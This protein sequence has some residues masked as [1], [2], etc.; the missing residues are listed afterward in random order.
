MYVRS[1][2]ASKFHTRE[3]EGA[4]NSPGDGEA[5]GQIIK[6]FPGKV[7]FDLKFKATWVFT[8]QKM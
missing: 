7:A 3:E 6:G 2:G 5:G 1:R 4:V 8:R